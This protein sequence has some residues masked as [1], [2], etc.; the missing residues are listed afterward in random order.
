MVEY[1]TA[2]KILLLP[3]ILTALS[4]NTISMGMM[5]KPLNKVYSPRPAISV[6]RT[7]TDRN[8]L[9]TYDPTTRTLGMSRIIERTLRRNSSM[10]YHV[11]PAPLRL[12][13]LVG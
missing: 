13:G 8:I 5:V 1:S 7:R 6:D 10:Y 12:E 3:L 2:A 11:S 4:A 9:K